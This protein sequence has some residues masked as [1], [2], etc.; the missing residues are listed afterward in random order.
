MI[1][2]GL[3]Q[4]RIPLGW[5]VVQGQRVPVEIDMEWMRVMVELVNRTGGVLG[6]DDV[7]LDVFAQG[8]PGDS[9]DHQM[10]MQAALAGWSDHEMT[11]QSTSGNVLDKL[12]VKPGTAAAPSITTEND[13]D[14]GVFFPVP[15]QVGV[16]TNGVQRI[17]VTDAAVGIAPLAKLNL[18]GV[19]AVGDTYLVESAPNVIDVYAGG[20]KI[21]TITTSGTETVGHVKLEGVTSTGA[22]GT[23]KLVFD[24][25]PVLTAPDLGTPT[26]LIATNATGTAA[27]LSVGF[28]ATA[29]SAPTTGVSGTKTPPA[30][31]TVNNGLIIA[32]S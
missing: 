30:S 12:I 8:A 11:M 14:T 18:D 10:T 29:G 15:N 23:G 22:T 20:V 26:V 31:L 2:L 27:G 4:A 5:A 7:G 9:S 28:A 17:G 21:L 16:A 3:P 6:V 24:L 1:P 13:A 32:W 19:T 25:N